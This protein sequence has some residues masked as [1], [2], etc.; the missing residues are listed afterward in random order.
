MIITGQE[1]PVRLVWT[2]ANNNKRPFNLAS[3]GQL[4]NRLAGVVAR[5]TRPRKSWACRRWRNDT[6]L[7]LR[8]KEREGE[9]GRAGQLREREGEKPHG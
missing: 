7:F 2:W 1:D 5:R 3:S 8:V 4:M 6:A 9:G